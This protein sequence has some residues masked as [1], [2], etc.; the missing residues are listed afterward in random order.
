ML[1]IL[2]AVNILELCSWAQI[3]SLDILWS[4]PVLLVKICLATPDH[5]FSSMAD[6]ATLLRQDVSE[7]SNNAV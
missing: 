5:H 2:V 1:D 3:S 6:T 4:F 7:Y